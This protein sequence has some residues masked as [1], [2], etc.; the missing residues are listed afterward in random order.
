M[1]ART[2]LSLAVVG[3]LAG[4]GAR[5]D[6]AASGAEA[7][8]DA[9][10]LQ[11]TPPVRV[12]RRET[13]VPT[14]PR[15]VR[16][17]MTYR[18]AVAALEIEKTRDIPGL[19]HERNRPFSRIH[20]TG[21]PQDCSVLLIHGLTDS[22]HYMRDVGDTFHNRGCNVVGVRLTGHG[23]RPE[24]L[25]RVTLDQWKE[26]VRRGLE[27]AQAVG[28][29][30]HVAGMSLGGALALDAVASNYDGARPQRKLGDLYLF[31]PALD[32]NDPLIQ[33]SCSVTIAR[34]FGKH[35]W[36]RGDVSTPNPSPHLYGPKSRN[37]AC[38]LS[39]LVAENQNRITRI[40]REI[41]RN[42]I[43]VFALGS[44][45]DVDVSTDAI[46][47]FMKALPRGVRKHEKYYPKNSGIGHGAATRRESNPK[48]DE[49]E[50]EIETFMKT[51]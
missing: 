42:G 12:G 5:A 2:L 10:G 29:T 18:N 34:G 9:L 17:P 36:G 40:A 3:A 27:L 37:G 6:T 28:K 11:A 21:G 38:Q 26:D 48:Y 13:S 50:G 43:G 23:T 44:E 35:P 7:W 16:A 24:D 8:R 15:P 20:E 32:P 33:F 39:T 22:P 31:Q 1:N 41:G 25:H 47:G 19:A 45:K 51:R 14:V 30:V 49:L 4:G 46:E